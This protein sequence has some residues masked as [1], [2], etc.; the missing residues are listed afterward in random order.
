[1]LE[2][3]TKG[4]QTD[5][6]DHDLLSKLVNAKLIVHHGSCEEEMGDADGNAVHV[7]LIKRTDGEGVGQGH[8]DFLRP[9][10]ERNQQTTE[11]D[12]WPYIPRGFC[13]SL[14]NVSP[15]FSDHKPFAPTNGT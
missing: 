12:S 7:R 14:K 5:G 1:M 11:A 8:F 10:L 4:I 15:P 13:V 3:L 6:N 9:K 2:K